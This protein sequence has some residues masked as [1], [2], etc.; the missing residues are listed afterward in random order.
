MQGKELRKTILQTIH[1]HWPAHVSEVI[2]LLGL[3]PYDITNVSKVRYH[4]HKLSE[5]EKIRTKKIGKA[6]VAWP[7]EMEKLRVI[8]ELLRE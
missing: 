1:E 5:E 2:R 4:F 6:L 7:T 8:D 3:D